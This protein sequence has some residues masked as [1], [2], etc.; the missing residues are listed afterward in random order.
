[1][2]RRSFDQLLR[3]FIIERAADMCANGRPIAMQ[4][5]PARDDKRWNRKHQ[6]FGHMCHNRLRQRVGMDKQAIGLAGLHQDCEG[7]PIHIAPRAELTIIGEYC[8]I[9]VSGRKEGRPQLNALMKAARNRELDC[10]LVWR[11][12]RFARSTQH[13]L[14][15]LEEFKHPVRFI[16]VQDQI[17]TDSPTGLHWRAYEAGPCHRTALV[18]TFY[19]YPQHTPRGHTSGRLKNGLAVERTA[20]G[21]TQ[22]VANT[23][24]L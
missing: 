2:G 21:G 4:S 3:R 19:T 15:A 24:T 12:D 1:M 10:V 18:I 9:A 7:Q 5:Q 8:D 6:L 11:F 20:A 23:L 22:S 13:L 16:S 17:D 14:N